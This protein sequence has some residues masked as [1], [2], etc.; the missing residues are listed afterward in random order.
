MFREHSAAFAVSVFGILLPLFAI[1]LLGSP[2][3]AVADGTSLDAV[4]AAHS[5]GLV[6]APSPP[7]YVEGSGRQ[8][9][10]E[11]KML[12]RSNVISESAGADNRSALLPSKSVPAADKAPE[13]S[14]RGDGGPG[15]G[16]SGTQIQD[17]DPVPSSGDHSVG[18]A[19]TSAAPEEQTKSIPAM[20]RRGGEQRSGRKEPGEFDTVVIGADGVSVISSDVP[21]SSAARAPALVATIQYLPD[22]VGLDRADHKILGQIVALRRQY[23]AAA[24]RVVGHASA[25]D[26]SRRRAIGVASVLHSMGIPDSVLDVSSAVY[27]DVTSN[28]SISYGNESFH[29]TEIWFTY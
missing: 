24:V 1:V 18:H 4:R 8:R 6:A 11:G 22:S 21:V 10:D 20:D 5:P 15:R 23:G 27:S 2:G 19:D 25:H 16:E 3:S 17:A 7:G 13:L 29:R 28:E 9:P 26:M 12:P 14:G